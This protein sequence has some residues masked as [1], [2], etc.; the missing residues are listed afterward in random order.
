MRQ[1]WTRSAAW[2]VWSL[3]AFA[4][5]AANLPA[6]VIGLT[7]TPLAAYYWDTVTSAWL[8]CPNSSTLA[9][10][11]NTPQAIAQYGYNSGLSQWTPYPT[12]A[13]CPSSSGGGTVDPGLTGNVAIYAGA[14]TAIEG[15][16]NGAS[17]APLVSTGVGTAP[18]WQTLGISGGGTAAN[19]VAG[20]I[21]NLNPAQGY[22][23]MNYGA[24]CDDSH[25]DYAAIQ[26]LL[27]A[28]DSPILVPSERFCLTLSPLSIT[29]Q[30]TVIV[31]WASKPFITQDPPSGGIDF[32]GTNA[33][34]INNQAQGTVVY[35]LGVKYPYNTGGPLAQPSA[36]T[37]SSG[38]G[39][40]GTGTYYVEVSCQ[41]GQGVGV[42]SNETSMAVT[43]PAGITV[44]RPACTGT[45]A[46]AT[47][48]NVYA[49]SNSHNETLINSTPVAI[50]TATYVIGSIVNNGYRRLD[51]QSAN[52]AIYDANGGEWHNVLLTT[53]VTT[54]PVGVADG[55]CGVGS[56]WVFDQGSNITG[57][58]RAMANQPG[59]NN[60]KVIGDK[61]QANNYGA[62]FAGGA[63]IQV[64]GNDF[65]D[66]Q[67]GDLW[68]LSGQPIVEKNYFEQQSTGGTVNWNVQLGASGNEALTV[69][70]ATAPIN[71]ELSKN[72]IQCNSQAGQD[73]VLIEQV[74]GMV[75]NNNNLGSC[76]G[77]TSIV[78]NDYANAQ[79]GIRALG[80]I[81]IVTAPA[82]F[83]SLTGLVDYDF[84]STANQ[85]GPRVIP[86]LASPTFTGTVTAPKIT[87]TTKCA[88]A[89]SPAACASA[90]A[91]FVT[92]A[93]GQMTVAVD[94]TAV[95][96]S[97]E[98]EI[99]F[100]SSLGSAL[101]VT[102]N[103]AINQ[104]SVSVRTGG[105]GF[106]ITV[107]SSIS[108][109]PDCFS[110]T[111]TN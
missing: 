51:D 108:V 13:G 44:A 104:P 83:S 72:F 25:N 78:E 12:L 46:A 48:W 69:G 66:N 38:T 60:V 22:N 54:F 7:P 77:Q 40:L 47:S 73:P 4:L 36:P 88:S 20:A 102:C 29:A 65:E 39:S 107:A 57:F 33:N 52:C 35:N 10:S 96:A 43:G 37:L 99:T 32:R 105:A 56:S 58:N 68:L 75:F 91:G 70:Q 18:V 28:G 67:Y 23:V 34:A 17:G 11:A 15:L 86:S 76:T 6:Q 41:N 92:V 53:G 59:S 14:G 98:I 94:T 1:R 19:T 106:I 71:V 31:G 16:T 87:T 81:S 101:G 30:N 111:I 63:A 62:V 100:D 21:G 42:Y 80:D 8:A 110:Y 109:N 64:T 74:V 90:S 89:A 9:P 103:T 3:C 5:C 45:G 93:A 49:A 2:M 97:S 85:L 50:G 24:Y 84:S 26:A 55:F 27:T 95:S 79:A 61:F 82:W